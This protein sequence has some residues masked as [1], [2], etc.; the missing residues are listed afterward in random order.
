MPVGIVM[1]SA[2]TRDES[3]VYFSAAVPSMLNKSAEVGTWI[4]NAIY[5]SIPGQL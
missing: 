2:D 1:G 5:A 4:G 3:F